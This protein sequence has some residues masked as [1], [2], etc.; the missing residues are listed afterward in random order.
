M[1]HQK[2]RHTITAESPK[3]DL[4]LQK[5]WDEAQNEFQKNTNRKLVSIPPRKI[6]DVLAQLKG[7]F[8][9]ENGVQPGTKHKIKDAIEIFL[10]VFNS[11][12]V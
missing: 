10:N 11:S 6:E 1:E 4:E 2:E 8:Q 12:A 5:L 3:V 7:K 9:P